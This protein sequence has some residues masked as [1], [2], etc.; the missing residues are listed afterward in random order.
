MSQPAHQH[1]HAFLAE[2]IC[3]VIMHIVQALYWSTPIDMSSE[4]DDDGH[5]K[6]KHRDKG[7]GPLTTVIGGT[8]QNVRVSLTYLSQQYCQGCKPCKH[9]H[10]H[11]IP[12]YKGTHLSGIMSC[13]H[14][15]NFRFRIWAPCFNLFG[16][17]N[18]KQAAQGGRTLQCKVRFSWW[19][20]TKLALSPLPILQQVNSGFSAVAQSIC[21]CYVLQCI[22]QHMHVHET[23]TSVCAIELHYQHLCGIVHD[24][25]NC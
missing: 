21:I 19:R 11:M 2:S 23:L 13:D 15:S 5:K 17:L 25:A 14:N 7:P 10:V 4:N 3:P 1:A 18:E 12:I 24:N 9:K 20:C 22:Q 6:H 8:L 16:W